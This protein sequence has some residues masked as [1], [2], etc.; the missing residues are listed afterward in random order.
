M[1]SILSVK[2]LEILTDML[3]L[4]DSYILQ[5]RRRRRRRSIYFLVIHNRVLFYTKIDL[6]FCRPLI[7]TG[8]IKRRSQTQTS[9]VFDI[10]FTCE[11][12]QPY[13]WH[14]QCNTD[15]P[16]S[17]CV[18]LFTSDQRF[19]TRIYGI[20]LYKLFYILTLLKKSNYS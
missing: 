1:T 14:C 7:F 2:K 6:F 19:S 16:I 3:Q 8:H 20:V 17:T 5:T 10:N 12:K 18:A 4:S 13:N 9:R 15:V 11:F